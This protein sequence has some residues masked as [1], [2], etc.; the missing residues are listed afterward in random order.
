MFHE[1]TI[2]AIQNFLFYTHT[3]YYSMHGATAYSYVVVLY[4]EYTA[5]RLKSGQ[6]NTTVDFVLPSLSECEREI[7]TLRELFLYVIIYAK[8]QSMYPEVKKQYSTNTTI[9][10]YSLFK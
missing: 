9:T 4:A 7:S 8:R 5:H 3:V 10:R 6:S 2:V 1:N